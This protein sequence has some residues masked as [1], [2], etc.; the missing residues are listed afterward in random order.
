M[1]CF[2]FGNRIN[3][4][5]TEAYDQ[6]VYWWVCILSDFENVTVYLQTS[7]YIQYERKTSCWLSWWQSFHIILYSQNRSMQFR[8]N[9]SMMIWK[10][11]ILWDQN[12]EYIIYFTKWNISP[13]Y[14]SSLCN[15]CLLCLFH[16]Q[17]IKVYGIS[18]IINPLLQDIKIHLK[19]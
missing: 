14:N 10:L 4:R 11:Q 17:D 9:F 6:V 19:G 2:C 7:L 18:K 1:F 8:F 5:T 12:M 13:M 16:V 3:N 15:I